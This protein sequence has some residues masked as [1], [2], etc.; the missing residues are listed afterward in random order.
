MRALTLPNPEIRMENLALSRVIWLA[1]WSGII[2]TAGMELFLQRITKSGIANADMSRAIGSIFTRS[3]ESAYG[4]GITIQIISG[5]IFAF[6]YTLALVYFNIHG[7]LGNAFAGLLLGFIH[8]AVVGFLLISA[9]AEHHP[10]P[11]FRE[12]GFN[13]AVAHWAGHLV[14]G[15]L[16]GSVI[17]LLGF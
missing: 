5:I 8:G 12:A 6:F 14:Y 4:L 2:G 7:Y 16:V 9:V 17:G 10:L 11:E 3:I 15:F 1:A 13:V